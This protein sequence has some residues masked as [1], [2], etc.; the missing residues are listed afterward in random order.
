MNDYLWL[1]HIP[2]LPAW[3]GWA[4]ISRTARGWSLW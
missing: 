3:S 2:Y 4:T 1:A